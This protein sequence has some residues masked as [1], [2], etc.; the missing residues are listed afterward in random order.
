MVLS[1][2]HFFLS[3]HGNP[4]SLLLSLSCI[5]PIASLVAEKAKR[6]E[7]RTKAQKTELKSQMVK[8]TMKGKG[9]PQ[10]PFGEDLFQTS[11]TEEIRWYHFKCLTMNESLES[12]FWLSL[13]IREISSLA[14]D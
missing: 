4:R 3:F 13:G 9:K 7:G 12:H 11:R 8:S 6:K 5:C 14:A 1:H 10:T 2:P